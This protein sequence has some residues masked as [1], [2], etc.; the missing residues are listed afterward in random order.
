MTSTVAKGTAW[1]KRVA[2]LLRPF[3]LVRR[4]PWLE[5]GDDMTLST[6]RF[7]FSIEAKDQL[8]WKPAEW[9]NQAHANAGAGEL[10]VVVAHRR[11][12]ATAEDGFVIM[13][14]RTFGAILADSEKLAAELVARDRAVEERRIGPFIVTRAE[15]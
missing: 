1:A 7:A 5:P 14:G 4:K 12:K 6:K 3:G 2:D 11:G 8:A 10:A 15:L 13:A 9:L